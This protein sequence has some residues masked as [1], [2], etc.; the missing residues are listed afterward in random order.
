MFS[1]ALTGLLASLSLCKTME[2]HREIILFSILWKMF[3][4]L[5]EDGG[6]KQKWRIRRMKKSLCSKS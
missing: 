5:K 2:I 4:M 1:V 6:E 3:C